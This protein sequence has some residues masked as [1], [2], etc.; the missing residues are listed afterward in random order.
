MPVSKNKQNC[1]PETC[2]KNICNK[3]VHLNNVYDE[4]DSILKEILNKKYIEEEFV[5][6]FFNSTRHQKSNNDFYL[7]CH[8]IWDYIIRTVQ[9]NKEIK[10]IIEK[11]KNEIMKNIIDIM[12]NINKKQ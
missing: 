7:N 12:N 6:D 1:N 8:D 3:A 11:N 4:I 5:I 9:E 10:K 2:S